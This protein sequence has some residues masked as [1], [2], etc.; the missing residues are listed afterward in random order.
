MPKQNR[1]NESFDTKGDT[2]SG[3]QSGSQGQ[4]EFRDFLNPRDARRDDL[5]PADEIKR[6]LSVHKDRSEL[7]IKKQKALR[8][9]RKALK[10][11]K[12]TLQAFRQEKYGMAGAQSP[13][14]PNPV[15]AQSPQFSNHN[16]H[17]VNMVPSEQAL[18][19]NQEARNELELQFQLRHRPEFTP[20][21][22]PKPHFNR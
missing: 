15:L 6:L 20:R 5:L 3:D 11:G 4:I 14:K 19:T 12:K 16:D 9:E 18:E 10:E 7:W 21:F 13:Y 8:E 1:N 17:Q 2:E 22:N